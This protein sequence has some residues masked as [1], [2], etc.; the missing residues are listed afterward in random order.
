M[1]VKIRSIINDSGAASN[2]ENPMIHLRIYYRHNEMRRKEEGPPG[3]IS[4]TSIAD[5]TTRTGFLID[6]TSR[7][8]RSYKLVTFWSEP[9][10]QN[11]LKKHPSQAVQIESK[12][13]PTGETQT[14]FGYEAKHFITTNRRQTHDQK[15]EEETLEG[16]YIEHEPVDNDC[17][18]DY[19]HRDPY[20]VFGT[21][22][23]MYPEIANF[24]HSGPVPTG[25]AVKLTIKER[26]TT[27]RIVTMEQIVEDFS[28]AALPESLFK[29]P[30]GFRKDPKLWRTH[31]A[32]SST[33]MV[34]I[35]ATLTAAVVL[36]LW[37][38]KKS[39]TG[40]A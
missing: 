33:E 21:A 28:D 4:V 34:L 12:T 11:Y 10:L 23:V 40:V 15:A 25:W 31:S 39:R 37:K 5:C 22:L 19:V 7:Q 20:Y 27:G 16:W 13:V 1:T 8:Y 30:S 6:T 14:F 26:Y 29:V 2:V 32:L 38:I 35:A 18:P 9:Q 36:L 24:N 3:D 17:A